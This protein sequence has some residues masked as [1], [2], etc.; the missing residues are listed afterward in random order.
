MV[1]NWALIVHIVVAQVENKPQ[2][3]SFWNHYFSAGSGFWGFWVQLDLF[4]HL[5]VYFFLGGC[6]FF[7]FLLLVLL[8]LLLFLF[9]CCF[10]LLLFLLLLL[11]LLFLCCSVIILLLLL[12]I[13]CGFLAVVDLLLFIACCCCSSCSCYCSS[14][15]IVAHLA[16]AFDFGCFGFI[17][18]LCVGLLKI[19]QNTTFLALSEGFY[20]FLS[21][22]PFFKTLIFVIFR[23][24][25]FYLFFF[26]FFSSLP[27]PSSIFSDSLVLCQSLFKQIFFFGFLNIYFFSLLCLFWCL[28]SFFLALLLVVVLKKQN[29]EL[30]QNVLFFW[31]PSFHECSDHVFLGGCF[32]LLICLL[33][34]ICRWFV[35]GLL[36]ICCC[37]CCF[38]LVVDLLLICCCRCCLICCLFA[39]VA[40][41]IV[42]VFDFVFCWF[43]IVVA[44]VVV[45]IVIHLLLVSHLTHVCFFVFVFLCACSQDAK[46]SHFLQFHR[47]FYSHYFFSVSVFLHSRRRL[48]REGKRHR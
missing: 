39:V 24:S 2:K 12:F 32:V 17:L 9:L 14:Y 10:V 30:Q 18:L 35:L 40:F 44:A 25:P 38:W 26:F 45:I 46:N 37:R 6:G 48:R 3:S 28:S 15:V 47:Y 8:L 4:A 7:F 41:S 43:V 42:V 34:L 19:P 13:C 36:L 11:L 5:C 31:S 27:F 29:Y 20:P 23:L 22:S 21:Q 16:L 1:A 33:L